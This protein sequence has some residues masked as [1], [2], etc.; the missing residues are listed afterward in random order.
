LKVERCYALYKKTRF[1]LFFGENRFKLGFK[2]FS[3]ILE[4]ETILNLVLNFF[5]RKNIEE[6]MYRFGGM[7]MHFVEDENQAEKVQ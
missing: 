7:I 2:F 6:S 3:A 4:R 1:E 5:F